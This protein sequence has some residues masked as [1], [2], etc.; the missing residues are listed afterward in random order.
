[1]LL[2]TEQLEALDELAASEAAGHA[3]HTP[4][5][6]AS[7]SYRLL[8]LQGLAQPQSG[9]SYCLTYMG[10]EALRLLGDMRGQGLLRLTS[11]LTPGWRFLGSEVLAALAAAARAS[12][13]VGPATEDLLERRGLA[14]RYDDDERGGSRM[15][16][17]DFGKGWLDFAQRCRPHLEITSDLAA[18][19][20]RLPPAYSDLHAFD[21]APAAIAQLEAMDLL[22][23]SVP[24]AEAYILTALGQAVF[25]ALEKGAYPTD[26]AVLD[27]LILRLLTTLSAQGYDALTEEQRQ[28]LQILGYADADGVLTSAGKVAVH[29]QQLVKVETE[30]RPASFA[31][32][33]DDVDLMAMVEALTQAAPDPSQGVTK[34]ALRTALVDRLE[35]VYQDFI[36]EY[37]RTT[38]D[39]KAR[40]RQMREMEALRRKKE[41]AFA[42]SA[43]LDELL[44]RLEAFDLVRATGVGAQTAYLLSTHG[45]EVL[46]HQSAAS[47]GKRRD[48][49]SAA[50]KAITSTTSAGRFG[51]PATDWARQ[52]RADGLIGSRGI[53]AQGRFYAR[54]AVEAPRWPALTRHEAQLLVHLPDMGP[55]ARVD[56]K[57][58]QLLDR[59]E[60]RG[61]IDRLVDSQVVCTGVGELLANAVRGALELAYPVTPAITRLL[62]AIRQIDQTLYAKTEKGYLIADA[63][64]E[65]ERL[66]GLGADTFRETVHLAK[67]G[68]Y[69]GDANLTDAGL[70]LLAALEKLNT[71]VM[72]PAAVSA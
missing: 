13:L 63:W 52:A 70:N 3:A 20:R 41:H 6:A 10:R 17:N 28:E 9:Q 40:K 29:A 48:I 19:I 49:T 68:Q 53:T 39:V 14:E 1:M 36:G 16:L 58:G 62:L 35:E 60:A 59:L 38:D 2:T 47:H 5:E 15:R 57:M 34:V 24:D 66:A 12:G 22:V 23:W 61:L 26:D 46:E 25:E 72:T 56:A 21:I 42:D 31:I 44:V 8:D 45:R 18:D 33:T 69:L 43:E 55:D 71:R 7:N 67:L 30:T 54:L 32:S 27:D 37:G 51:A 50:V 4:A 65:V 11:A 64:E